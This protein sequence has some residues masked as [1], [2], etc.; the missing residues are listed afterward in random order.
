MNRG[1]RAR[2]REGKA[3]WKPG[4]TADADHSANPAMSRRNGG[5]PYKY[6]IAFSAVIFPLR[7]RIAT[8]FDH[9]RRYSAAVWG[10]LPASFPALLAQFCVLQSGLPTGR[11][12][13]P[14]RRLP[15][16]RACVAAS[17]CIGRAPCQHANH[18][19]TG[20][21]GRNYREIAGKQGSNDARTE[22][23]WDS[24]RGGFRIAAPGPRAR[25][26]L[27]KSCQPI[28]GIAALLI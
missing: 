8:R 27:H 1:G 28:H 25:F 12:L 17:G 18:T 20:K 2:E 3:T 16:P 22:T 9:C 6:Y 14:V 26:H 24:D 11:E 7:E 13:W 15:V 19:L 5:F 21:K 10:L 4:A 23:R